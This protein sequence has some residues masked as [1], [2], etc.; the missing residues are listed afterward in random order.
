MIT[1]VNKLIV[2]REIGKKIIDGVE[3]LDVCRQP[4]GDRLGDHGVD[5]AAEAG[6]EVI[7]EG[8]ETQD[9]L[10]TLRELGCQHGQGFLLGRPLVRGDQDPLPPATLLF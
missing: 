2:H 8:I 5:I 6:A 1:G 4:L 10:D 7:A 3:F 9:Q